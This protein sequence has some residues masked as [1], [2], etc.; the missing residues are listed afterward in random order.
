MGYQSMSLLRNQESIPVDSRFPDCVIIN[1]VA[2]FIGR[3]K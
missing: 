2:Q 3:N 1:V